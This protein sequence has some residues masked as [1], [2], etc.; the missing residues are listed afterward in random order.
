[1]PD[2]IQPA[3]I[4]TLNDGTPFSS[5]FDDVY[6]SKDASAKHKGINESLAVFIEP[7]QLE[8]RFEAF[9]KEK[10]PHKAF[11]IAETGFG[12]G[13]NFLLTA[14]LFLQSL[15]KGARHRLHFISVEKHPIPSKALHTIT[16]QWPTLI[17]I[18]DKVI[19]HYPPLVKGIHRLAI[20]DNIS[21][22]LIFDDAA[23]GFNQLIELPSLA[24]TVKT[25]TVDA[26]FLDGFAPSKNPEMWTDAL[27]ATIAHLSHRK[28]TLAT[29]TA[30]GF[31]SR[32]LKSC[33]FNIKKIKGY[34]RKREMITATY[35]G[36]PLCE[37]T[38][39]I[40]ASTHKKTACW[41]VFI[42]KTLA[43]D[44]TVIGAG[45]A[46]L[47]TAHKLHLRGFKVRLIDSA[48][49][50]LPRANQ[51]AVLF[52][53]FSDKKGPLTDFH[54]AA[55]HSAL[56]YYQTY[57]AD[58]LHSPGLIQLT[59]EKSK[60]LAIA[61]HF[62][63]AAKVQALNPGEVA[64]LTGL[65]IDQHALF[66]PEGSWLDTHKLFNETCLSGVE[67]ML[68]TEVQAI[69]QN[70]KG[71]A[72]DTNQGLVESRQLVLATSHS[73]EA[74]LTAIDPNLCWKTGS[75]RGQVS[76]ISTQNLPELT[77]IICHEGY[78]CP[79]LTNQ[80]YE[81]GA[82]YD[83]GNQDTNLR[84]DSQRQ[85]LKKLEQALPDFA[86]KAPLRANDLTGKVGFRATTR[87]YLPIVGPIPKS[88]DFMQ[89][90]GALQHNKNAYLP[91]LGDYYSG[92]YVVTGLGSKGYSSAPL[93]AEIL[94][95]YL[96]C[97]V[98][99]KDCATIQSLHPA[100]FLIR[101]IVQNQQPTL[102]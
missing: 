87:D 46:G 23:D 81:L 1:M 72:L 85:N 80:H 53:S 42:Q 40:R 34:G 73:A 54:F 84:E 22:T 82:S 78:I 101:A 2:I 83:L 51:Q 88:Y 8:N 70:S 75:I 10:S 69:H 41:P 25:R 5:Q 14:E 92:L 18:A 74:Q 90:Y 76:H 37:P 33:G 60:A 61:N 3:V 50:L 6:F 71:W 49:N 65:T 64:E 98:F 47:C 91:T 21:L 63:H 32:Q 55:F 100:R 11:T 57:H 39:S 36:L 67:W 7:N 16:R 45:I 17:P 97:D 35:Q 12:T 15:P 68:N 77:H 27:F 79:T 99:P 44:V 20:T 58:A 66:Y 52:P 62:Q 95:D 89:R 59:K 29:F 24:H 31:V 48:S 94:A 9:V 102:T 4:T 19:A 38:K 96:T 30:A 56:A 93:C 26:W 28:T 86:S 43:C 13:L